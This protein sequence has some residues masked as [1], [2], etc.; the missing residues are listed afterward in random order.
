MVELPAALLVDLDDTTLEFASLAP[1]V[2]REVCAEY[3]TELTAEP[4]ELFEAI[5]RENRSFWADPEREAWGRLDLPRVRRECVAAAARFLEI[6]RP[7]AAHGLADRFTALRE[8]RISPLPGAIEALAELQMRGVRLALVTNGASDPQRAKIERFGL[9]SYFEAI[10]IEGELGV[11][12]PDLVVFREAVSQLDA[13]PSQVWMVGD[14]LEW[15][16][17]GP[18]RLGILG[19]WLDHAG[20]GVPSGSEV[21]PDR[22]VRAFSELLP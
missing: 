1:R 12:K 20:D 4:G 16:V 9:G 14:N 5:Q 18:Q 15:D 11:G 6:D 21:R 2:W 7:R 8:E 10:L 17:G 13:E 3:A 19:I 22:I